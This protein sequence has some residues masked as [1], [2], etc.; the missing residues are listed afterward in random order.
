MLTGVWRS[1]CDWEWMEIGRQLTLLNLNLNIYY[2]FNF[3][4]LLFFNSYFPNTIFFLLYSV[5][6]QLHIHIYILFSHIIM[7]HRK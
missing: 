2:F 4:L 6:T 7:L 1:Q 5:V 3:L